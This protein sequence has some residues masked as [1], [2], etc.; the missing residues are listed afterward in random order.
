[1]YIYIYRERKRE[2]YTN[3]NRNINRNRNIKVNISIKINTNIQ[4]INF[5][6]YICSPV[7]QGP[8]NGVEGGCRQVPKM[9][10]SGSASWGDALER[11]I[12]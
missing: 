7:A 3:I 6:M 9:V 12:P 5:Y 11:H 8:G 1:M 4:Y 2:T 10:R